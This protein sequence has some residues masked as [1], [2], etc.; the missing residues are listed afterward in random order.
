VGLKKHEFDGIEL[1]KLLVG[2]KIVGFG[3][4]GGDVGS[5]QS[6]S[7]FG[8]PTEELRVHG[9]MKN[10]SI[11][12]GRSPADLRS[13][14]TVDGDLGSVTV[15][16]SVDGDINVM[17]DFGSLMLCGSG[18]HRANLNGDITVGGDFGKMSIINGDQYGDVVVEGEGPKVTI[19]GSDV[20]GLMSIGGTDKPY[21]IDGSITDTG[22][23]VSTGSVA[24]LHIKG[25]IEQGGLVVVDGDLD[26]LIVDGNIE[27]NVHVT[28]RIG[29]VMATNV[30]GSGIT[31]TVTAGGNIDNIDVS[32]AIRDSYVLAG[33]DPGFDGVVNVA[34]F[35]DDDS[36]ATLDMS[37]FTIDG[38]I[39]DPRERALSGD[40]KSVKA[41]ILYNSVIAAGVSPGRN[42]V[43]G[44]LDGSDMPGDGLSTIGKVDIGLTI[45]DGSPFGIFADTKIGSLKVNGDK[46][47]VPTWQGE[48]HCWTLATP[49]MADIDGFVVEAGQPL[50]LTLVDEQNEPVQVTVSI[51]GPGVGRVLPRQDG[52][53]IDV[54]GLSGASYQTTVKVVAAGGA[55]VDVNSL[56]SGDDE[57]LGSLTIDGLLGGDGSEGSLSIGG[58]VKKI[59]LAGVAAGS[60]V[61]IGGGVS[62][63]DLGVLNGSS[64]NISTI[65]IEGDVSGLRAEEVDSY[66]TIVTGNVNSFVVKGDM[67]GTLQ[68]EGTMLKKVTIN[69]DM[70]GVISSQGDINS[71]NVKGVTAGGIRAAWNIGKFTTEQMNVGTVAAG[72]DFDFAQIR[73]DFVLSTLAAGLDI[74]VNGNPYSGD[75]VVPGRGDLDRVKIGGEFIESNIVA[76][77]APGEDNMFGTGDDK[78]ETLAVERVYSPQV[79]KVDF[80]DYTDLNTI[81]VQ[82]KTDSYGGFSRIGDVEITGGIEGSI[83]PDEHF[84]IIAAGEIDSVFAYRQ[85]FGQTGN[86]ERMTVS[87]KDILAS[88][89]EAD[90]ETLADALAASIMIQTDGLDHR[91]ATMDELIAGTADDTVIFGDDVWVEF[92][93]QTNIASFHKDNGF[94]INP[95]GT[96][97]YKITLDSSKI[98][99]RQGV[100]LDGEFVGELPSGDGVPEGDFEYYFAVGDLGNSGATA[101]SPFVGSF[102]ENYLWKCPDHISKLGVDLQYT[103]DAALL[104]S[105]YIRLNGFEKGQILNAQLSSDVAEY[106]QL[107]LQVWHIDPGYF[108]QGVSNN[109]IG[110]NDRDDLDPVRDLVVPGLDEFAY[111]NGVFYGYDDYGQQFYRIDQL[112]FTVE[113]M[114]NNLATLNALPSILD[115]DGSISSLRALAG[116]IDDTIWGI[117]EFESIAGQERESLVLIRNLEAADV[118]STWEVETEVVLAGMSN[119][120]TNE[121]I[122]AL[123]EFDG[124][125]YGINGLTNTLMKIHS[126]PDDMDTF[127]SVVADS[128]KSLR[129]EGGDVFSDLVIVG[130]DINPDGTALLAVHDQPAD[131]FDNFL[132][133]A[134]YEID[135][136]SGVASLWQEFISS[137]DDRSGPAVEPGGGILVGSPLRGS[138]ISDTIDITFN[139]ETVEHVLGG[140]ESAEFGDGDLVSVSSDSTDINM[141]E[142][143]LQQEFIDGGFYYVFEVSYNT[144]LADI[145]VDISDIDWLVDGDETGLGQIVS[146]VTDDPVN[147]TAGFGVDSITLGINTTDG[148]GDVKVYFAGTSQLGK[149]VG[150][151]LEL[152][153]EILGSHS[154][155]DLEPVRDMILPDIDEMSIASRT[156]A[157][158]Y[159]LELTAE[160]RDALPEDLVEQLEEEEVTDVLISEVLDEL[161]GHS[162]YQDLVGDFFDG[163]DNVGYD[164][165]GYDS[166]QEI[167]SLISTDTYGA[168]PIMVSDPGDPDEEVPLTLD[169]LSEI[170]AQEHEDTIF[171]QI[172]GL[173]FGS[174]G[175]DEL[176][177][178]VSVTQTNSVT[179]L[180]RSRDSLLRIDDIVNPTA[181]MMELSINNLASEGFSNVT[182]LAFGNMTS[183]SDPNNYILY[184]LDSDTQTL[185]RIDNRLMARNNQGENKPNKDFGK[186]VA[187]GGEI[188]NLNEPDGRTLDIVAMD[189]DGS[190]RLLAV[191]KTLNALVEISTA[192]FVPQRGNARVELVQTL[193]VGNDYRALTYDSTDIYGLGGAGFIVRAADGTPMGDTMDVSVRIGSSAP[194][195]G[196]H[197]FGSSTETTVNSVTVS[198]AMSNSV[199]EVAQAGGFYQ[200]EVDYSQLQGQGDVLLTISDIDWHDGR[201]DVDS[202]AVSEDNVTVVNFG[203]DTLT[204]QID[205]NNNDIGTFV[206]YFGATAD[207]QIPAT[208]QFSASR[209]SRQSAWNE[210]INLSLQVPE[211]GDYLLQISSAWP[212]Y[213]SFLYPWWYDSDWPEGSPVEYDLNVKLFDDGNSDFGISQTPGGDNYDQFVPHNRPVDLSGDSTNLIADEK[214]EG[215]YWYDAE[216]SDAWPIEIRGTLLDPGV[217]GNVIIGSELGCLSDVDVY[218]FQLE[219]GQQV[220][221]DLEAETFFGRD[222]V[223]VIVG[224]YNG[225]LEAITTISDSVDEEALPASQR[226]DPVYTAQAIFTMP[227][228][229]SVVIDPDENGLGTYYVVVTGLSTNGALMEVDYGELP[230]QLTIETTA[231]ETVE[232]PPS[233]L[234]WL[235]F[236]NDRDGTNARAD[237]LYERGLGATHKIVNRPPFYATE[238]GLPETMRDELIDAIAARIEEAYRNAGL[239]ENEIEFTTIKPGAAGSPYSPGSTYS[240]VIFGGKTSLPGLLAIAENVDRHNS[241]RDDMAC[242]FTEVYGDAYRASGLLDDDPDVRFDQVVTMLAN[243]GAHELGHILGL[244]HTTELGTDEPNNVM[245]YNED[246]VGQEFEPRNVYWYQEPGFTNEIDMLLRNIGSGTPMGQ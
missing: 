85:A 34:E 245:G 184:G 98:V 69:G 134:L 59:K 160:L 62:S 162:N 133:D 127:G 143:A 32:S 159:T 40:I 74:G 90:I 107:D 238:F 42:N 220:T 213:S 147:V 198:S 196:E 229:A 242:V 112:D 35:D 123:A 150:A 51:A 234:V 233:Q 170:Y 101:Y 94:A 145:T 10:L 208:E 110:D 142:N 197:I 43:F 121:N 179:G 237:Y 15:Y 109:V 139:S 239:S 22:R 54:I 191:E 231:A 91:F 52:M 9:D 77:V 232:T 3:N 25:D 135:P 155:N 202:V 221:V 186:A 217:A 141:L 11:G 137:V 39:A 241:I 138:P 64:T 190:G 125:L 173:E 21:E 153:G 108:A 89:I 225:D 228:H 130:M 174:A 23:F 152:A 99:N 212:S 88:S 128:E 118:G 207:L 100:L 5:I 177:A 84:A 158:R 68:S 157:W 148:D 96:N 65:N 132:T 41:D 243:T 78:L 167:F 4:I 37:R 87:T 194:V 183:Q 131:V 188:G 47:T 56:F 165:I 97:Y 204:L 80:N 219:H 218:T 63:A 172:C 180:S 163:L 206:L 113:A 126:D 8:R 166:Q 70:T 149:L 53:G 154:R 7:Y 169:V 222:Y 81:Y 223:D 45:S 6:G 50:K 14:L 215:L 176:W 55:T 178:I 124:E 12:S 230:Y 86:V 214:E 49:G 58:G 203:D 82:F 199:A 164:T 182:E 224:I 73:G 104:D 235:S 195:T 31:A 156:L 18:T 1:N 95:E 193:P 19:R 93:P 246:L 76:G 144:V 136:D 92:D 105:D 72:G 185:I 16:G 27:G 209:V 192:A 244:E 60:E 103:A 189:F 2:G 111:G 67:N 17:D 115:A 29:S 24:S 30:G 75:D 71:I 20:L 36:S 216:H 211:D 114:A 171:N 38:T 240:T 175:T 122:V 83:A 57:A 117:V 61:V 151:E 26:E 181:D 227:N 66:V 33:F 119:D 44:D 116:H 129:D 28:G 200:I 120:L 161:E 140:S 13:D 168:I 79:V 236:G 106:G 46:L 210:D 201:G 226:P 48:F 205:S 102:P 187:V 146:V